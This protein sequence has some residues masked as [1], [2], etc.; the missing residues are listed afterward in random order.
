MA[1]RR[2]RLLATTRRSPARSLRPSGSCPR[3]QRHRTRRRCW[4]RHVHA[5]SSNEISAGHDIVIIDTPPVL[6][7]SDAMAL[8]PLADSVVLVSRVGKTTR[9]EAERLVD[10]LSR[11][12]DAQLTGIV[13]NDEDAADVRRYDYYGG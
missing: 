5:S 1:C 12:P 2:R 13:A 3:A 7:V 6:A 10:A 9:D 11:I 4:L 8:V